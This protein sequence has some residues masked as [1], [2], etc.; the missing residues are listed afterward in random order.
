ML[1]LYMAFQVVLKT[2]YNMEYV[3]SISR[4][5]NIYILYTRYKKYLAWKMY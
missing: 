4:K 2:F 3:S 1:K 5:L